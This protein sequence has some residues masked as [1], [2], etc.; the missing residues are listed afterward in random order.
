[1]P[2]TKRSIAYLEGKFET[3]DVPTQQDFYDLFA[4]FIHYQ[5][6]SKGTAFAE[7][8]ASGNDMP[9]DSDAIGSGTSGAILKGDRVIFTEGGTIGQLDSDDNIFSDPWPKR[10][11]GTAMQDSPTEDYHWRLT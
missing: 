11:I 10:T 5:Q 1:M 2:G 7:W 6:N 8:D 4:S 3:G 9:E